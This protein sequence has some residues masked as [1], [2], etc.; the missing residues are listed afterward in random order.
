MAEKFH[1]IW[2][3]SGVKNKQI[4]CSCNEEHFDI[5]EIKYAHWKLAE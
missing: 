1:N 2:H 3:I 5:T 4:F